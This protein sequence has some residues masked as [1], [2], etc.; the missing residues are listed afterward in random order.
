MCAAHLPRPSSYSLLWSLLA[1][2]AVQAL[3]SHFPLI[4]SALLLCREPT[5]S[6]ELAWAV[7][8]LRQGWHWLCPCIPRLACTKVCAR[9]RRKSRGGVRQGKE[10][11]WQAS[12]SIAPRIEKREAVQLKSQKTGQGVI[13]S[14]NRSG[15]GITGTQEETLARM[16]ASLQV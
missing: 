2:P 1:C 5:A 7:R 16:L 9:L 14:E 3:T 4:P 12:A 11:G 10:S 6:A 15:S 8:I 13:E